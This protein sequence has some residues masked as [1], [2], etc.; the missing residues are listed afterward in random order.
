MTNFASAL[1]EIVPNSILSTAVPKPKINFLQKI[2]T[3]WA[4]E[5]DAEVTGIEGLI[6]LSK[7][8]VKFL[9]NLDLLSIE[10]IRQIEVYTRGQCCNE[11]WHLCRKGV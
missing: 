7:T 4:G 9:E 3:E 5:T 6:Q 2:I 10:K 1:E 8:K 11:Q